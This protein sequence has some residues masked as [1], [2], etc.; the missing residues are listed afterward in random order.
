MKSLHS[1]LQGLPYQ[2]RGTEDVDIEDITFD[3]RRVRPGSLF[4]A[5]RGV[6][7]D[8]RQFIPSAIKAGARAVLTEGEIPNSS[9]PLVVVPD[10]MKALSAMSLRFWE[11][12]SAKLRMVAITGTNGKT[13]TSYLVEAIFAKAGWPTAVMG[14]INYRFKDEE[15]AAPNTTPF[16]SEIHRFLSGVA[17]KGAKACVMEVSSHALALG[18][19]E[20]IEYDAAIFTNLTQ[21]HLDFHKTMDEYAAAKSRLFQMLDPQSKKPYP[22][23]AIINTDDPAAEQMIK[24]SRVPVLRYGLTGSPDIRV[25]NVVSDANGSRFELLTPA[26]SREMQLPLLGDYNISNALA[27]AGAALSQGISLDVIVQALE[28]GP[29]VPGRMEQY[30]SKKGFT[31]VVDYAHTEDALRKVMGALKKLKPHRLVTVF[32]CGGDRDRAKRPLMGQAA[33]EMSDEVIVTSDNPRSEDPSKI[34]LDVE[35]GVRRVR[36]DHY[37]IVLDRETAIARAVAMAEAGDM[38]LVA[39]K[40]HEN[41]QILADKTISFDDREVV[42]RLI[43]GKA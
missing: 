24:A 18:R 14:T 29:R 40:G 30:K 27:A 1:L 43:Q 17:K 21:D 34:A 41:Y 33:A 36:S 2:V 26:G 16:A 23:H 32:G 42:K 8:G 9:V 31:V 35:V 37:E 19:V 20:G 5:L 22:R 10:A 7:Q 6:H 13:T 3:S 39:G 4:V 25:K 38:I 15:M 11:N 12:P 28:A